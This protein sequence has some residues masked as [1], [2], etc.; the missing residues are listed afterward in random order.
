MISPDEFPPFVA[1]PPWWGGDLQTMRNLLMRERADL[2]AFGAERIEFPDRNGGGDILLGALNK[3]AEASG[4]GRRQSLMLLIHGLT[5]DEDSRYMRATAQ[6]LLSLG[7][8]V[9]RL[10]LRGAG[11]SRPRCRGRYHAGRS[12]DIRSVLGRLDGRLAADGIVLV[13]FSLGGNIMLKYLA[14]QGSRAP[15]LGA[16]SISAP[17]DLKSTQ[18]RMLARRNRRY[19]DY[20][21]AQMKADVAEPGIPSDDGERDG[22]AAIRTIWQ[23][24]QEIV[25]PSAGFAGADDYYAKCSAKPMLGAIRAPTLLIHARNDPWIPAAMYED[26]ADLGNRKLTL[27]LPNGGGHVGFHGLGSRVAWHDRCIARF[28]ARLTGVRA[29]RR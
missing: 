10:N 1:R 15:V 21:L 7:H 5:G 20:M 26:I 13:G 28:A 14:E 4:D 22:M 12:D 3:P 19:H 23:F 8:P 9:L 25:A 16:V 11:P 2:S 17:I 27:L 18:V 29:E 6:Y 24:D